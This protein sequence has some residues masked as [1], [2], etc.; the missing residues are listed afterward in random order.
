MYLPYEIALLDIY[1]GEIQAYVLWRLHNIYRCFICSSPKV[2]TA[3]VCMIWCMDKQIVWPHNEEQPQ[4][5]DELLIHE[6]HGWT[7]K[8]LGWMKEEKKDYILIISFTYYSRKYKWI[9]SDRKWSGV[10]WRWKWGERAGG[11]AR[12]H[13]V[14]LGMTDMFIFLNVIMDLWGYICQNLPNCTLLLC[15]VYCVSIIPQ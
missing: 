9:Y 15:A 10:S 13:L 3:W 11:I 4:K 12:E 5:R 14:N 6:Q 1:A 8:E 2:E 7:A